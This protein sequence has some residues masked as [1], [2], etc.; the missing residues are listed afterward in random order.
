MRKV[1][2]TQKQIF[3]IQDLNPATYNPRTIKPEA[4]NGLGKSLDK[5]GYLQHIVVNIRDGKNTI[6]SGHQRVKSYLSG[7]IKKIECITVDFDEITEKAANVALNAES[8]SGDWVLEDLEEILFELQAELPEEEFEALN[9][10]DLADE[11]DIELDSLEDDGT[12]EKADEVPEAPV[13]TAIKLGDLV[14]LGDHTVLCGDST[15]AEDVEKLMGEEKADMVFTDPPYNVAGE[16]KN[17]AAGVSKAMN[18]LEQS[19]WDKDFKPGKTCDLINE[20]TKQDSVIY[21]WTSHFLFGEI[22][23]LCKQWA[24]YVYYCVWSK[25]NPMPS[26]SKHH[27]TWNTEL[28]VYATKGSKRTVNFP[29]KGHALST[30]LDTKKSDG[31]HPTQKP[32]ELCQTPILFNSQE[33]DLVLDF[34]LGSGSTLIA[35]EKTKRRCFGI[36]IDPHYV[37]VIISR[38]CQYTGNKQVMINDKVVEWKEYSV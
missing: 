13:K 34:F 10:D 4:L 2:S 23:G 1:L 32:V 27:W 11:L 37:S 28:C 22:I 9:Y 14:R 33:G 38:W 8:I 20:Y 25:P 7:D 5:F 16:S 35:C 21:I 29:K 15:K 26:L 6:I 19:E 30:W 17:Y 18:K 12:D 24:D 36:E 31:T 3:E